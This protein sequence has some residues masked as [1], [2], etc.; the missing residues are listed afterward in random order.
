[1]CKKYRKKVRKM[2]EKQLRK[3]TIN[4]M[5][6]SICD[7]MDRDSAWHDKARICEQIAREAGIFE[8]CENEVH[9]IYTVF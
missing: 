4:T 7:F 5:C 1:M 9:K 3:E 6:E 8:D 2:N